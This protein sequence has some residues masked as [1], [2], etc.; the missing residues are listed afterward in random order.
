MNSKKLE[1]LLKIPELQELAIKKLPEFQGLPKKALAEKLIS[2]DADIPALEDLFYVAN[3][4]QDK[5]DSMVP[6]L[7]QKGFTDEQIAQIVLNGFAKNANLK[8][9][10]SGD[11]ADP[12]AQK[13]FIELQKSLKAY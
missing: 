7:K 2:M 8:T 11:P 9:L 13:Q 3:S 5:P 12:K 10:V 4:I 1:E 6:V